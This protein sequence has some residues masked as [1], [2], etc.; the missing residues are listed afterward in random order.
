[1]YISRVSSFQACNLNSSLF[2]ACCPDQPRIQHRE[3]YHFFRQVA[4]FTNFHLFPI[5][6]LALNTKKKKK[7]KM[8][9][10]P[11][12]KLPGKVLFFILNLFT[13][14]ALVYEGYNQGNSLRSG[15][16]EMKI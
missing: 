14:V 13:S 10:K 9:F 4:V 11:W 15:Y 12:K 16:Q 3:I 5:Y 6:L 7:I 1:M 8:A 2:P